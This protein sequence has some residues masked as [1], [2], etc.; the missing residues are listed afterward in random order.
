M[1]IADRVWDIDRSRTGR[2]CRIDTLTQEIKLRAGGVFWAP[3]DIIHEVS[4]L[5][6]RTPHSLQNRIRAHFELMLH[7]DG[8]G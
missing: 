7:M 1:R 3:F 4:S 2:D 6:H 8:A 5:R